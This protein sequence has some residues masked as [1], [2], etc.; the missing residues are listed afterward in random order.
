[1]TAF[2]IEVRLGKF[3]EINANMAVAIIKLNLEHTLF[4]F[5][6]SI[7]CDNING[8]GKKCNIHYYVIIT[9]QNCAYMREQFE[10]WKI[11]DR[12]LILFILG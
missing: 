3:K 10:Y 4:L 7:S 5:M 9:D 2:A 6:K 1:M 11:S 8:Y 12:L